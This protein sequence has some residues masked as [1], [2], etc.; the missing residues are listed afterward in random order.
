MIGIALAL[1]VGA[2]DKVD[3]RPNADLTIAGVALVGWVVPELLR[4]HLVPAHCRLCDGVDNTGLPGTGSRGSLNGVDAW[5]HDAMTGWVLSRNTAGVTSDILAY[6]LAPVAAIA[7]AWAT[8]GPHASE[9]A[10][11]RAASIVTESALVSGAV[12][13]GVKFIAARKRPYVRYGNGE[14]SGTYGVSD[15]G[16]HLGFPSGHTA[17][18]T[19]LGVALATTASIEESAAA[20]WLWAGAAVGS[21]TTSALRMIAEKHYFTDVATGT[22]IG[23]AC[24][25]VVPLLHRRG[26]PLS[27]GSVSVAA[28]GPAFALTGT[29]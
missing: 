24:G 15:V 21:V 28:Q 4:D 17:W 18:V 10:G 1:A 12:V 3:L 29:F 25:V 26:G 19:S 13:E 27:S 20:P 5:F 11:W 16:S 8:T 6:A 22:V 23:A 14:A 7:G 2:T 9:G